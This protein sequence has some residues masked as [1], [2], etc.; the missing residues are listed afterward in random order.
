MKKIL[1][2]TV[3]LSTLL[4]TVSCKRDFDTDVSSVTVT[5]GDADFT[6]YVSIGNSLTSGYRDGA[7]YIDGQNES[8]PSMIAAQMKLA[9]GGEF[10]QP[11]MADNLGGI[12]AVGFTNKRVLTPTMGLGFA[13]GTGATTLAN[14]YASGPYNNMGVPGA[15]SYHLVAPGY[16][17]PANLPLGKANPYF[18]RFAK[19]PATSS[20]LSDAMDMKPSFFSL[21]I[22]NNDVLSYATNGGMNST[23][24]NGVTTYTPA[25]VQTGNLDPTTYKGNDISDPNVVGGVIKSVLDGL[26]SVGSTKGVIANIPNVTAIPFFNRVPYNTIALDATKAAAINSSLINP[27]IGALNYLGQSGRFVP[28]V[29][30]NNPV[31]IV[32]NSLPNVSA[33]LTAVLTA[34]GY[35]ATQAA[36]L[37]NAFGQARQAKAGELILLTASNELG[38]DAITRQAPTATSQFIIGASFPLAD[39]FSLTSKE[40]NNIATAVTAYNTAISGLASS[41]SIALVDANTKMGELN[42]TA[43]IQFDGVKY[44]ATFVTGGSFSLDG[45]HPTGRGYAILANEF[46]KAINAKYSSTLPLVNVNKYSGVTFP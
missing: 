35:P 19:N 34:N 17:N 18:V 29:A 9:G 28:V 23:T 39:Q 32:D 16:G 38:L 15:K 13:A 40:V 7:L 26:K 11:L 46:I 36:F 41:Y 8:F 6:K 4:F 31:I 14:I 3:A 24:V 21:W 5:K 44:T 30:G 10:K 45:V 43:G 20:V 27:L 2:S 33:G 22:G 25:V 42:S 37:G 1:I 12:P